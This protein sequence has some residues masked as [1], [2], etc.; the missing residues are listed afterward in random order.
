MATPKEVFYGFHG[1]VERGLLKDILKDMDKISGMPVQEK[2]DLEKMSRLIEFRGNPARY[3]VRDVQMEN[4]NG[5]NEVDYTCYF[6][7]DGTIKKKEG[8]EY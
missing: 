4:P 1:S 2:M 5:K 8:L 7:E 3:L 6:D